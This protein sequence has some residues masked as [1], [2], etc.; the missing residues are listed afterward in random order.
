MKNGTFIVV[1]TDFR[2]VKKRSDR[3]GKEISV[4]KFSPDDSIMA[5]GGMDCLVLTYNVNNRF[6]VMHK[7]KG[8]SSRIT[9]I[10][11]SMDG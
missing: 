2:P 5:V 6:A 10:D 8:N 11:F 1:T 3:P 7:M 4:I 9:H